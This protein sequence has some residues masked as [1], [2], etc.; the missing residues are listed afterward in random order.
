MTAAMF[1]R[2]WPL[3]FRRSRP[4]FDPKD[5]PWPDRKDFQSSLSK[6]CASRQIDPRG[7]ARLLQWNRDGYIVIPN[8]VPESWINGMLEDYER[9]WHERPLCRMLVEGRDEIFWHDAGPRGQVPRFF[10]VM[11]FH[12]VSAAAARIMMHP[13]VLSFMRLIFEDVPVAMQTL[14]FE[15]S[16]QQPEHQDF[17]YVKSGVLPYLAASWIACE[18]AGED[19]GSVFYYPGSHRIPKYDFGGGHLDYDYRDPRA[20]ELFAAYLRKTCERCGCK[21]QILNARKGDIFIWHAALVH[22]GSRPADPAFTRKSLVSHYSS[23]TAYPRDR[24]FPDREP[25][26]MELNGGV[27]Y[28]WE[29]PGHEEGR[30]RI[31]QKQEAQKLTGN[32]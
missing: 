26:K 24:R 9:A 23:V 6:R 7:A 18:D 2:L 13:E 29:A 3:N 17:P 12:N 22:G 1:S 11:D 5:L 14:F 27:Y 4:E 25:R 28:A 15:Y 10:R 16:S 19:N 32:L 31:E 21:K 20:P 30:Y 8:A